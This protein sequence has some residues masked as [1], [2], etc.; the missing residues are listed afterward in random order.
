MTSSLPEA[1]APAEIEAALRKV[2]AD[3]EFLK[4]RNSAQFLKFVVDETLAG[5]GPRL[6]AFTIAVAALNRDDSFD[7]QNNS[8]VRVQATRLRQLL[9]NYYA[10]PGAEDPVRITM[11]LGTYMATFERCPAPAAEPI[12]KPA[13][14]VEPTRA[15]ST[16]REPSATPAS[17]ARKRAIAA[18]AASIALALVGWMLLSLREQPGLQ[19]QAQAEDSS[20]RPVVIVEEI[21]T[22]AQPAELRV[23]TTRMLDQIESGLS[24]YDAVVVREPKKALSQAP[25]VSYLLLTRVSPASGGRYDFS[26]R[27]THRA[28]GEIVWS[29]IFGNVEPGEEALREISRTVVAS[30][31]DVYGAISVDVLRRITPWPDKPRGYLC[32]LSAFDYLKTRLP[33]RRQ[34]TRDCLE[35][36]IAGN[37]RDARA[38]AMLAAFLVRGYLDAAAD[39]RGKEDLRRALELARRAYENDPLRVRP[40]HMVFLTRFYSGRFNE[41]FA[42]ADKAL[43]SNPNVSVIS[44]QIGAAYISRGDYDRG[45]ALLEPLVRMELPAPRYLIAYAALA[46]HM[47]GDDEKFRRLG[48]TTSMTAS[49]IGLVMRIIVCHEKQ[50]AACVNGASDALRRDY[51]GFAADLR[52]AFDRYEFTEAIKI[53]LLAD[54]DAAGFFIGH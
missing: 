10:G 40:Q 38:S 43:E 5:R 28:S 54:L 30:V 6:K 50:D 39:S 7:A 15:S 45:E 19:T 12:E 11:P 32:I 52:A 33:E 48:E 51:P 9:Q 25:D 47:R 21:E 24:A 8:I 35:A 26:F 53:R 16:P 29:R 27:L 23:F 2:L 42:A 14:E 18:L 36:E 49:A 20:Y 37:P 34:P 4:N 41:A 44:A 13:A 1:P 17:R 3:T 22:E 46:A 31:G